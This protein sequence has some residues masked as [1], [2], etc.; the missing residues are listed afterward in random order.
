[1]IVG[2]RVTLRRMDAAD[3]ADVIRLRSDPETL[4]QLFSYAPPTEASHRAWL[5]RIAARDDRHEFVIV[6]R[7]S[8]QVVGTIGLAD[9]DRTH[10]RAEYG[11]LVSAEARG[12]GFAS[13]ATRLVLEYGFRTLGLHRVYLHV[14]ADNEPARRLYERAGFELEGRLRQHA[15]K[16][17]R[18]RDVL[19]MGLLAERWTRRCD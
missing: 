5:A 14:F 16:G 11:V 2:E 6:D 10:R 8:G 7:A 12:K 15:W 17:G 13:E 9:I 19:V 3:T 4:T 18:V 1:M